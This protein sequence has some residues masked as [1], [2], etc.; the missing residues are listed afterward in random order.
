MD[1]RQGQ[2]YFNIP[3]L[4]FSNIGK[5]RSDEEYAKIEEKIEKDSSPEKLR[6]LIDEMET[7]PE[8]F[9]SWDM[10]M[11]FEEYARRVRAGDYD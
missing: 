9:S 4:D 1:N 8:H 5:E 11:P 2:N 10:D 3:K 7:H 6:E